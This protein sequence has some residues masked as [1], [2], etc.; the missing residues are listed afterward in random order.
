M[1][2]Y[3]AFHAKWKKC[4]GREEKS[5]RREAAD[6]AKC[7]KAPAALRKQVR[8]AV[9]EALRHHKLDEASKNVR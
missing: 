3:D 8:N 2:R 9:V 7:E 1:K 6:H 5:C 4:Y